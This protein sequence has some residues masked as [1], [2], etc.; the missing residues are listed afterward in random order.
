M[1]QSTPITNEKLHNLRH[2][3]A[4]ILASAVLEMFPKAQL[5]V[6]PTIETGFYYDFLLPRSLTPEDLKKLE[7]RMRELVKQKLGFE[8]Q[9][10]SFSEA[11]SYFEERN[12][13]FKIELIN[14]IEKHGTTVFKDIVG[15][16]TTKHGSTEETKGDP[17]VTTVSLYHTGKF[18]DL[19][20]GGHVENTSE[21]DAQ[22]FMLNKTSGA[23]WRGDQA[24][25]QMQRLYGLAFETKEA[26]DAYLALQLEMEKR[27]HKKLGPQLDLFVFSE[28]VGPGLPLWTPK[29]T[30]LRIL[31]DDY[32]WKLRKSIGY[33]RV[34]IPHITKKE[35]YITSGHWDKFKDELFRITARE[36]HEFAMKPMN[37]PHH[38]QIYARKQF[39]YRELPQRY[40][41]TT[42]C[43]RDEQ[44]GELSGLSRVRALTQDDA[45]VF[46]RFN[47]IEHE[48]GN[49]WD[50]IVHN[51]F[52]N[53]LVFR[54]AYGF[55][56]MILRILKNIWVVLINGR[57][58]K[59]FYE[60]S[61]M[62]EI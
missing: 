48:L 18:T 33:E 1:A 23:Y 4:H 58:P 36:G 2:S 62:I 34:E 20:R 49:I 54:C 31:L 55:P 29:G 11:R 5:G 25:P 7:K 43:Y 19:C 13:P 50:K 28:L 60:D 32:V 15:D 9:E 44:T 10:M 61:L 37:C 53:H 3:L 52:M 38:T 16:D 45:H 41:N 51:H 8:R 30:M 35:L 27:D 57:K 42:Y 6:G 17:N 39:S 47:Q 24:N 56:C 59:I 12:Q 26:L 22:A 40:A 21:I 14:D 46:C